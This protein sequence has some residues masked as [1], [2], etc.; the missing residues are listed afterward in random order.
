MSSENSKANDC[1][2]N[3]NWQSSHTN[4]VFTYEAKWAHNCIKCPFKDRVPWGRNDSSMNMHLTYTS[5]FTPN[6]LTR[7]VN[8]FEHAIRS[9][10]NT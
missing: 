9:L 10:L 6:L 1:E 5:L 7:M 3:G 8:N 4:C 2:P